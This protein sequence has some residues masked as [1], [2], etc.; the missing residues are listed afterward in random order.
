M[1]GES[2]EKQGEGAD[3]HASQLDDR[4][5]HPVITIVVPTYKRPDL[6]VECLSAIARQTYPQFVVAVCDNSPEA[7]ARQVVESLADPRFQYVRREKNLGMLAN[8]LRGFNDATT[9]FV[10][11]VDDDD[12]LFPQCLE[13]LLTPFADHPN[14]SIVFGDL[15][16]VDS[17]REV[18]S[19]QRRVKYLP[20][21][22]FLPEGVHRPFTDLAAYGYVFLMASVLRRSSIDWQAVPTTA[23]T[24]YDR[25]LTL[26]A[27][28]NGAAGYF[29]REPV[30][31]YRVHDRS[32]GLRFTT[33][34]LSGALDVLTRET[35][36]VDA[37]SRKWIEV[38]VVRTRLRLLR[39]YRAAG[40][41]RRARREARL[42]FHPTNLRILTY[43][44]FRQH[45]PRQARLLRDLVRD[46]RASRSR[47]QWRSGRAAS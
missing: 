20:S 47:A 1:M 32:D 16:V 31:A 29:V 28:R 5:L 15:V 11:E 44:S 27:S 42:L 10:M 4:P 36:I 2:W 37:Q 46:R 34:C 39:A 38:E 41:R 22:D 40:E 12:I 43:L 19:R 25:Y 35:E 23:A 14:L 17:E 9:E 6:L 13:R 24:A 3:T 7:E 8:V 21:L 18:M 33:Q 30:M 45:L 26:A